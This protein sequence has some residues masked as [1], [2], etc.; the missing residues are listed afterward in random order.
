[1]IDRRQLRE[2]NTARDALAEALGYDNSSPRNGGTAAEE[3]VFLVLG[4]S[5]QGWPRSREAIAV[6]ARARFEAWGGEERL[7]RCVL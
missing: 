4:G 3:N 5:S 7:Q 1:M 2:A 6:A